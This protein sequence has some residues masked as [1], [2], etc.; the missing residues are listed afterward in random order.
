[1][2]ITINRLTDACFGNLVQLTNGVVDVRVSVDYGPRIMHFSRMGLGNMLY[3]DPAKK[4][5]DEKFDEFDD[6]LVIYGGHRLWI[7]PEIVPRCYHPD[8]EAV[9][10]TPVNN[11]MRFTAAVEK[12]NGIQKMITVVLDENEPFVTVTH[13]IRNVGLWDIE[14]ALWALTMVDKGGQEVMPMP[15]SISGLLP[16]RN[17]S[18]WEYSEMNDSRVYF[19]KSFITIIQDAGK[20]NPFKLGYNNEAG[21]AAYFNKN[22]AFIKRFEPTPDGFYP[23]NGCSY[24]TYVNGAFLEMETLGKSLRRMRA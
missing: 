18:F 4:A 3:N 10:T 21:W 17:F 1:M 13:T 7:S 11:G 5:L 24:E 19:G 20:K 9:I 22:Q 16:N 15:D 12:G 6:Q 2:A 14:L 8:N 23:D